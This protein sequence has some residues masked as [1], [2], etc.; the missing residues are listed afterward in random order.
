MDNENSILIEIEKN[1][2]LIKKF[3]VRRLGLFGSYARGDTN[4]SSDLDFVV[5][6]EKKSFD[7]YMDLK[8]FLEELFQRRVDLV[9]SDAIKPQLRPIIMKEVIYAKGI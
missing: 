9:I 5:E 3:G 7:A 2:K 8:F 4:E 1:S 6:F